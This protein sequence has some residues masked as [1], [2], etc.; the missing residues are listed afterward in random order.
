MPQQLDARKNNGGWQ[1]TKWKKNNA[2]L[3]QRYSKPK[4]MGG[5]KT[6]SAVLYT[7]NNYC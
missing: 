4:K 1:K 7:R 5:Q 3:Q 2:Y 6:G